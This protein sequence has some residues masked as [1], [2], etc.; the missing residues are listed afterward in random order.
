MNLT[1]SQLDSFMVA[2]STGGALQFQADLSAK[3]SWPTDGFQVAYGTQATG[4]AYYIGLALKGTFTATIS[5]STV[6]TAAAP[7]TQNLSH[8]GGTPRGAL[9]FGAPLANAAGVTNAA[10][11]NGGFMFG[12]TDGTNEGFG[13]VTQ[14]HGNTTSMAGRVHSESKAIGEY[15]APTPTAVPTLQS[16]ADSALGSS[17][18]DLTWNDTDSVAR[19]YSYVIFGDAVSGTVPGQ[20]Y[21][22]LLGVGRQ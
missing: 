13:A 15:L 16:E 8:T 3:G 7:Q 4:A 17:T 6:P 9:L 20:P 19:E 14:D 11:D 5:K 1:D 21:R 22:A 2:Y 12:A 18:L 10:G